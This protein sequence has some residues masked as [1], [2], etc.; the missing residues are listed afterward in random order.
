M[1]KFFKN[2]SISLKEFVLE[3]DPVKSEPMQK[4]FHGI[5]THNH[6][7]SGPEKEDIPNDQSQT[8]TGDPTRVFNC[9]R[10]NHGVEDLCQLTVSKTQGPKSQIRSSV[11][12]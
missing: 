10:E 6:R 7:K 8:G 4:T 3:L 12:N 5:H 11:G 2:D 9:S 1:F